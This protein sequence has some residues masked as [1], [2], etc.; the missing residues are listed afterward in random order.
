MNVRLP[1]SWYEIKDS[2]WYRPAIMTVL[3]IA[4]SFATIALDNALFREERVHA[5]WL[6]EGGAE[7]ARG[8]LSAIA[9]SM[10]LVV[11]TAFSFTLVALQ[12]SSSQ[13]SP[14]IVRNFTGDRVNQYVI[15]SFV[16]TFVYT[17]LVLRV[18]RSES[19]D[20]ETFVP[21]T[22]VSVALLL[23]LI[24]I[25]SLIYFFH[26]ATRTLQ[27][28]VVITRATEHARSA[29]NDLA[30]RHDQD[31]HSISRSPIERPS[32]LTPVGVV[33]SESSGYVQDV[34]HSRVLDIATTANLYV[35]V[36][37]RPGDFL[38]AGDSQF[39]LWSYGLARLD[40]VGESQDDERNGDLIDQFRGLMELG[41]E[42]TLERDILF[43]LQQVVDIALRALSTAINDPTTA[44]ACL[45]RVG[46]LMVAVEPVSGVEAAFLDDAHV[47]RVIQ[48]LVTWDEYVQVGLAHVRQFAAGDPQVVVHVIQT[49]AAV[50]GRVPPAS[51]PALFTVARNMAQVA[52]EQTTVDSDRVLIRAA[53]DRLTAHA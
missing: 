34:V 13:Y 33:R 43:G 18:V 31:T 40:P 24:C 7:G 16:A 32:G 36:N 38:L 28:S 6:F 3:A 5:W 10:I 11:T 1:F 12:L 8:V 50:I 23:A 48:P 42:R 52:E 49:V 37:A 35:E 45:D 4:L 26:H 29:I 9:S 22:S 25:A 21:A 27:V 2:L 19:A 30:S 51:Q 17:L 15:G 14:R 47:L 39:T 44:Q 20:M 41:L 46:E 53:L